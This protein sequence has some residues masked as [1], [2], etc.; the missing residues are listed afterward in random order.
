[1]NDEHIGPY[2][3]LSRLG[4]G[5]VH[6]AAGPTGRDVAIRLLPG[7]SRD[8]LRADLDRMRAVRSP[9]VVD[10]LDGDPEAP[11][12]YVVSRFVPGHPLDRH[13]AA[14]GPL[15]GQALDRLALDLAKALAAIHES[16]LAH[17]ALRP[18]D[19][20]IVDGSPVIVD[21][22]LA[23][24]ADP[25]ADVRSW[26][27]LVTHAA[28]GTIPSR[29]QPL[30]EAA[31]TS[32]EET[33]PTAQALVEALTR[34]AQPPATPRSNAGALAMESATA[35]GSASAP[36]AVLTP[37]DVSASAGALTPGGA[38]VPGG[39]GAGVVQAWAR[40]LAA[41]AV[42]AVAAVTVMMP[43]VGAVGSVVAVVVL[44]GVAGRGWGMAVGRTAVTLACAG[45]VALMV[46]LGLASLSA[47]GVEADPL[48]AC[49]LGVGAGVAVLWTAPGVSGPRQGLERLAAGVAGT[50]R[51]I[52]IGGVLL[53]IVAFLSVVGAISLTPSFA[54]MYGLQSSLESAVSQVQ[55]RLQ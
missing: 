28:G 49:A 7:G 5:D 41:L 24:P 26:A 23:P 37:G 9:Y 6:R 46:T 36:S 38:T 16:G 48:G 2:R 44:R 20:L 25:A 15:T 42:V 11:R 39:V 51:A 10:V 40:L 22:A 13:V 19:V 54:P 45:V 33:R 8:R 31:T 34:L 47:V 18:Q 43:V 55:T 50:P 30:L 4:T 32:D 17:R 53:G 21:F 27:A 3:L 52:G 1:M 14:H 29:L 35:S 12:P